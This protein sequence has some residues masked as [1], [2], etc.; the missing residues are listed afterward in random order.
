[1]GHWSS[2]G[3][4]PEATGPTADPAD[5]SRTWTDP[6]GEPVGL[7]EQL[8]LLAA[9]D[10]RYVLECLSSGPQPMG[11]QPLVDCV[12]GCHGEAVDAG[13]V[14]L[15]LHHVHLPRL[16]DAGVLDYEPDDQLVVSHPER[17]DAMLEL[18]N[19]AVA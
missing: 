18:R 7:G 17:I 8:D 16:A 15:R 19:A 2:S 4:G 5:G 3:R 1:M 12:V 9:V 14:R 10:R 6:T 11:L 13:R